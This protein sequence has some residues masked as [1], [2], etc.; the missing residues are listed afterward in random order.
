MK[1]K[2]LAGFPLFYAFAFAATAKEA[3]A[4]LRTDSPPVVDGKLDDAVWQASPRVTGFKTYVPDYGL[5]LV[6][7]TVV[8]LAYDRENLYFAFRCF[9]S[10]PDKI[11][12]SITRRDNIR[13]D[14]WICINLDSFND[15]QAL[16][17]F[18][19]ILSAFRG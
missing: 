15:Q 18:T 5:D 1:R 4:P 14:D 12:S 2:L 11:K 16:Y 3:L 9:D 19:S 6:G 17:G 10:E 8:H 13:P 7:E